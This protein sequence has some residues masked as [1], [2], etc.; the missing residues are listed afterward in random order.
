MFAELARILAEFERALAVAGVAS[1]TLGTAEHVRR[2]YDN[3]PPS[4]VMA[5][6]VMNARPGEQR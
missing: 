6:P 4:T 3:Q 1:A 5:V 2:Q